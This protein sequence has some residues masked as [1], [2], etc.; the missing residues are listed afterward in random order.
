VQS[1]GVRCVSWALF[2][3]LGGEVRQKKEG[4]PLTGT[5]FNLKQGVLA[6]II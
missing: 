6:V 3:V 2:Q 1:K 5:A 4:R